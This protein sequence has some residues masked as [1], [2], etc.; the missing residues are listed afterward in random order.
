MRKK[1]NKKWVLPKLE[2]IDLG[3]IKEQ[4][5]SNTCYKKTNQPDSY[6]RDWYNYS[7]YNLTCCSC[8]GNPSS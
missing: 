6:W 3:P 2:R 1:K 8:P 4:M 7:H 5:I